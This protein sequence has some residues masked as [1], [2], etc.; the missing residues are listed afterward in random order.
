M[1]DVSNHNGF[2][3]VG[4]FLDMRNNYGV[5]SI[6]TK[7][8][9][10][11]Y[12]QD[13]TARG[14]IQNAQTS[15]LYING[16]HYARYQNKQQAINEG[17][18]AGS[19]ANA[20]G[21]PVGAVLVA[22][23]EDSTLN[24][25]SRETLDQANKAFINEVAKYGYRGDVY[26]MGSW[27]DNKVSVNDDEGWIASYPYDVSGKNWYSNHNSWQWASNQ[28]FA[29][30]HG[31]FDVSQNYND[32]YTGG[33]KTVINVY[34]SINNIVNVIGK[35]YKAYTTYDNDGVSY[36]GTNVVSGSKW[37]SNGIVVNNGKPFFAIAGDILLPQ[38]STDQKGLVK[39]N[40]RSDYGV[41]GYNSSGNS[42]KDSNLIFK[43]GTSWKYDKMLNIKNVGWCYRVA[44]DEYIPIKYNQGSGFNG[45]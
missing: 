29:G 36:S 41:L 31:V 15:G 5:K 17:Q 21:L 38:D 20:C 4:N 18:F 2:M 35:E 23:V 6:T 25:V 27:V 32:F 11:T 26:T 8:S 3:T 28:Q 16:Y 37:I 22:D 34:E 1:V 33:Q 39:I 12:Y 45:D 10:G 42:I 44:T 30:S 40:Y 14:N 7:I 13:P 19:Y 43:G 24:N 9:E